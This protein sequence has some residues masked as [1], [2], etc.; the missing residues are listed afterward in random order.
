MKILVGPLYVDRACVNYTLISTWPIYLWYL[1]WCDFSCITS[2]LLVDGG[3]EQGSF[4]FGEGGSFSVNMILQIR[5]CDRETALVCVESESARD[6][7]VRG[8]LQ[9]GVHS[10]MAYLDKASPGNGSPLTRSQTMGFLIRVSRST[11][12]DVLH[13]SPLTA[14]SFMSVRNVHRGKRAPYCLCKT[15][16]LKEEGR[17]DQKHC[18]KNTAS[19]PS[20]FT[21]K[22][23]II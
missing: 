17:Y 13:R 7:W 21:P 6:K 20:C 11:K 5:L 3:A 8:L 16:F 19:H 12:L 22:L 18:Q 1:R 10:V 4:S 23:N 9:E 14:K 15:R 2:V